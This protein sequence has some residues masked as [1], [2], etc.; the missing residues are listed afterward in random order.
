ML[1]VDGE[2]LLRTQ[3]P[4]IQIIDGYEYFDVSG[5]YAIRLSAENYEKCI[6]TAISS[7]YVAPLG[8][9]RCLVTSTFNTRNL[10]LAA[11]AQAWP[12]PMRDWMGC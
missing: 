1:D 2:I 4:P 12:P 3:R 10:V 11:C 5:T 9:G 7:D 6:D 8:Q